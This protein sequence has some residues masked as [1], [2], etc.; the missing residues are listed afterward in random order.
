MLKA[1]IYDCDGALG[2]GSLLAVIIHVTNNANER[3]GETIPADTMENALGQWICIL[4]FPNLQPGCKGLGLEQLL[5][6]QPTD[7]EYIC[8]R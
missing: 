5:V 8:T 4:Y 3:D 2:V 7:K 6:N 1:A